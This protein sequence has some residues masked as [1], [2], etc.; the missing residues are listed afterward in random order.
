MPKKN[1]TQILLKFHVANPHAIRISN[2]VFYQIRCQKFFNNK[3]QFISPNIGNVRKALPEAVGGSILAL[4]QN[5]AKKSCSPKSWQK[6]QL[7]K[8]IFGNYLPSNLSCFFVYIL[9]KFTI[10]FNLTLSSIFYHIIL[11][12]LPLSLFFCLLLLL[13][14]STAQY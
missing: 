13:F 14:L 4:D 10:I 9:K 6:F 8:P 11:Q 7:I 5:F 1:S 12:H 3:F 2:V